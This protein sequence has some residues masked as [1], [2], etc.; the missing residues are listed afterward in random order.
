[1]IRVQVQTSKFLSG[2][3]NDVCTEGLGWIASWNTSAVGPES[4]LV[5]P[6]Y[7]DMGPRLGRARRH[8]S[9]RWLV[10]RDLTRK[11]AD[12]N[13]APLSAI[14]RLART[15]RDRKGKYARSR[16]HGAVGTAESGE[17]GGRVQEGMRA[18]DRD[19]AAVQ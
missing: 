10:G 14:E 13:E 18:C 2:A 12:Q 5:A 15:W 11:S 9:V 4:R 7:H 16:G 1:M 8:A 19:L 3:A 17:R 6:Y